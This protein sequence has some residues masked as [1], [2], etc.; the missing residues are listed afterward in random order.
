MNFN[1]PT[2]GIQD[3]P[4]PSN[5]GSDNDASTSTIKWANSL[6]LMAVIS[7]ERTR[8][9]KKNGEAGNGNQVHHLT[10]PKQGEIVV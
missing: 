7:R 9:I 3:V 6:I 2:V 1:I 5:K 8:N 4:Q 10:V